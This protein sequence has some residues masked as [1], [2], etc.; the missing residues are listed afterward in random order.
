[1]LLG[2]RFAFLHCLRTCRWPFWWMNADTL[3]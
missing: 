2:R 1:V 3:D